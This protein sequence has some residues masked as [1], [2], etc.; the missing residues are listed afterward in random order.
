MF[1]NFF[2]KIIAFFVPKH[3]QFQ[4]WLSKKYCFIWVRF[5]FPQERVWEIKSSLQSSWFTHWWSWLHY[6]EDDDTASPVWKPMQLGKETPVVFQCWCW[7]RHKNLS[8]QTGRW[9]MWSSTITTAL[10]ITRKQFLRCD[11]ACNNH[12]CS[13]KLL[14]PASAW[15]AEVSS[16]F[17]EGLFQ[18]MVSCSSRAL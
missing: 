11:L 2:T 8:F 16:M 18:Y 15:K 6:N 9:H 12:N 13:W 5:L 3:L 10:R 1:I 14:N 4:I 7:I 17:L